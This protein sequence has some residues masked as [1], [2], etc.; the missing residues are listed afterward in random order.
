[1]PLMPTEI[2]QKLISVAY[3]KKDVK[4]GRTTPVVPPCRHLQLWCHVMGW[5]ASFTQLW[6]L[7]FNFN[8]FWIKVER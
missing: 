6:F 2:I 1:M 5:R 7:V 8:R 3:A 4:A